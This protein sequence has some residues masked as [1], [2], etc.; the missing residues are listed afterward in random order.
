MT[1][2]RTRL[3]VM[4][5]LEFLIWGAWYPLVFGYL[6]ALG[7]DSDQQFWILSGFNFAAIVA[8]ASGP[9]WLTTSLEFPPRKTDSSSS[10]C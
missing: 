4:M 2:I 8:I 10:L 9:P 5:F 6:P 3:S 1:L 7:F